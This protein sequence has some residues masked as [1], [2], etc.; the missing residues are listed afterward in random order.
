VVEQVGVARRAAVDVVR[1]ARDER[2]GVER[3]RAG[4]GLREQALALRVDPAV[5]ERAAVAGAA[6]VE[7]DEVEAAG[8]RADRLRRRALH[9]VHAGTARPAGVDEDGADLRGGVGGAGARQR[10]VDRAAARMG[11]VE[12]DLRGR[13]LEARHAR[14]PVELGDRR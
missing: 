3:L 10:Q 4:E 7:A 6:G 11:V 1:R 13:A 9:E 5:D 8:D 14:M 2:A 12:R